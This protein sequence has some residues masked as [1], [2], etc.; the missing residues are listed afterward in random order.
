[1][2]RRNTQNVEPPPRAWG[3]RTRIGWTASEIRTT[4]T[5]VGKTTQISQKISKKGK[6]PHVRG[7]DRSSSHPLRSWSETPPRAWGRPLFEPSAPVVVGN[8]PTC[9]GK[10]FKQRQSVGDVQKHPHVRGED[11][12]CCT[13]IHHNTETPHGRGE[14]FSPFFR[15]RTGVEPPPRAWGR[16]S[17]AR[18]WTRRAG[19]TPTGVGKTSPLAR[20]RRAL[21]KHPHVRG[22]DPHSLYK[23]TAR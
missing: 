9:V 21:K 14:E 5:C 3:R 11:L 1:M 12:F 19:N 20:F 10:T 4:P 17:R 23:Q 16:R 13:A 18:E 7:E 2:R 6:H 8:T 15:D 22:E